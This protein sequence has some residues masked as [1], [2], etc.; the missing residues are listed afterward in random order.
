MQN[1]GL[2]QYCQKNFTVNFAL[3]SALLFANQTMRQE[4]K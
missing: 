1:N 4:A 2:Q 3:Q